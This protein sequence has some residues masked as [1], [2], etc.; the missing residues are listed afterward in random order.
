MAA[1]GSGCINND[2]SKVGKTIN[3]TK[4]NG[5]ETVKD[6]SNDKGMYN[7]RCEENGRD[8]YYFRRTNKHNW[9]RVIFEDSKL[10]AENPQGGQ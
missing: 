6:F 10:Y 2:V 8:V 3:L 7:L 4:P 1:L 5:C 9:T